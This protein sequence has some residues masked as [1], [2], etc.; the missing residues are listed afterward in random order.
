MPRTVK[1]PRDPMGGRQHTNHTCII[2]SPK[3]RY[4]WVYTDEG[5]LAIDTQY[6][7]AQ[8]VA[9]LTGV[10]RATAYRIMQRLPR[11]WLS[12]VRDPEAP[13]C[14]SVVKRSDLDRV[15]I[16]PKGNPNFASGIYQQNLARRLRRKKR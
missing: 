3:A 2:D 6:A 9:R 10:S 8:G 14:F 12:D 16:Y 7:N 1:M 13:K 15:T 11:Y 5:A 4:I